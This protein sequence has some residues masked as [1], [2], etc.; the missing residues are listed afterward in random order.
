MLSSKP[1]GKPLN[2]DNDFLKQTL[3]NLHERKEH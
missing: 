1:M 3:L 2:D